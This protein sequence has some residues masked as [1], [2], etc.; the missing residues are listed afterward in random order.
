MQLENDD[1]TA[2]TEA[3]WDDSHIGSAAMDG[4]KIFRMNGQ[5]RREGGV[6]LYLRESL[7]C[8]ELGDGDEGVWWDFSQMVCF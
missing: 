5:G 3:C 4:Y 1:R 6:A 2:I 8:L 7:D